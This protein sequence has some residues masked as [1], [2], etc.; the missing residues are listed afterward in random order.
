MIG[1]AGSMQDRGIF[2]EPHPNQ[3]YQYVDSAEA[4]MPKVEPGLNIA[5]LRCLKQSYALLFKIAQL[6]SKN[7]YD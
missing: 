2:I 3:D 5:E 1:S 4:Y 7:R 6:K